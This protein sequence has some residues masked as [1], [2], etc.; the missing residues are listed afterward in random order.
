MSVVKWTYPFIRAFIAVCRVKAWVTLEDG[1]RSL[2]LCLNHPHPHVNP[3]R[4]FCPG[5]TL[6][7]STGS[8]VRGTGEG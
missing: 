2:I 6:G 7:S 5:H 8:G 4:L 3:F 1:G